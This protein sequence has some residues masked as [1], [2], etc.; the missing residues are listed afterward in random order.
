MPAMMNHT[1]TQVGFG[2]TVEK[3]GG[4]SFKVWAPNCS[5]VYAVGNFNSWEKDQSSLMKKDNEGNWTG[6]NTRAKPGDTYMFYVE[7][8]GYQ[9][10]MR[11]PYAR[12]LTLSPALPDCYCIIKDPKSY[13]WRC[14]SFTL[15]KKSDLI[16]YQLHVGCFWGPNR[17]GRVAKFLDIIDRIDHLVFLGVNVV[18]LLPIFEFRTPNS[19]GYNGVDFFSPEMDYE[20]P[21]G[22]LATYINKINSIFSKS[23]LSQITTDE[24]LGSYN[25]FKILTDLLHLHKIA[26]VLDVVYN[27]AGSE[28]DDN[29]MFKLDKVAPDRH[30]SLYF[31]DKDHC[32]PVFDFSI[33]Q[34]RQLLIDNAL[35]LLGELRVDGLRFDQVSVI[36]HDGSPDG[37]SF[38][39]ELTNSVLKRFPGALLN[40]EYWDVN[41]WVVKSTHEGG[42]GFNATQHNALRNSV[43]AAVKKASYG[44]ASYINMDWIACALHH[45][46]FLSDQVVTAIC[47]HDI[48]YAGE[49]MDRDER[50]PKLGDGNDGWSV[51]A[52]G[53]ARVAHGILLTSPGIPMLFMGQEMLETKKWHDSRQEQYLI[54]WDG[55]DNGVKK[56]SD[57]TRFVREL[58]ALRK[59]L[60]VLREGSIHTYHVHNDNRIL[61]F[62]RGMEN[63]REIVVVASFNDNVFDRY[64][65]GFPQSGGWREIFNSDAYENFVNPSCKGNY[66]YIVAQGPSMHSMPVSATITIPANS[67]LVFEKD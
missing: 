8:P 60:R 56:V 50:I 6:Y 51:F 62:R 48:V 29:S 5:K 58:I 35:Y 39:Q 64:E 25:Q 28:V 57:F 66:G 27:H 7:G 36:D 10:L 54:W 20:V 3:D 44:M 43:R 23:G 46:G 30:K 19:M 12:E 47:N 49:G 1:N 16:F 59:A 17:T 32:G 22:E 31:C 37:W 65:M 26:V 42:A 41:T 53:R 9:K 61:G 4:V 52:S 34:V 14:N 13:K 18:Q 40:A 33:K 15:Q 45:Q 63:E 21:H 38:C 55:L 24:A 2:T 67:I 11:D